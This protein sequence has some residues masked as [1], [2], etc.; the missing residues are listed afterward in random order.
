MS[1]ILRTSLWAGLIGAAVVFND[2]CASLGPPVHIYGE[3]QNVERLAGDWWGEYIGN[4]DHRRQGSI[5]FKLVA[6]DQQAHGDVL[7]TPEGRNQ[8]YGPTYPDDYAWRQYPPPSRVL[9]I[10]F[11]AID[12][13]TV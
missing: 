5:S 8:P 4:W 7:M 10:R 12:R 11:V 2:S 13:D 1:N 9:T 3:P 6:G